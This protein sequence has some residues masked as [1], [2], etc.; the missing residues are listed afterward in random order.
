MHLL[1]LWKERSILQYIF[2]TYWIIF[3][4]I[5]KAEIKHSERQQHIK[6]SKW[7][8]KAPFHSSTVCSLSSSCLSVIA[9]GGWNQA[10]KRQSDPSQKKENKTSCAPPELSGELA[11]RELPSGRWSRHRG[12]NNEHWSTYRFHLW[13]VVPHVD[14]GVLEGLVHRDSLRRIYYQHFG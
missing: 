6:K 2:N 7:H 10:D 1:N 11:Q 12:R 5:L 14:V 13:R 4:H 9:G 3:N 8:K